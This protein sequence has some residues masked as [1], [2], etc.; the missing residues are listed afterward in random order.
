MKRILTILGIT[1]AL[2]TLGAST[3]S[4]RPN[5]GKKGSAPYFTNN[6][7]G[8][9]HG[10]YATSGKNKQGKGFVVIKKGQRRPVVKKS[11]R[12]SVRKLQNKIAVL[13]SQIVRIQSKIA[14]MRHHNARHYRIKVQVRKLRKLR[15]NLAQAERQLN[16][17]LAK[18]YGYYGS[19]FR[20]SMI[21]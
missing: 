12:K 7:N 15:R 10:G 18:F 6:G 9:G 11:H 21:F 1:A 13:K 5:K 4:A 2:F 14:F 16:R 3:A 20:V 19:G 17:K 8:Q